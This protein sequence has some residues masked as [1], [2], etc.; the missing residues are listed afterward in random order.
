MNIL[1][2]ECANDDYIIKTAKVNSENELKVEVP[3]CWNCDYVNVVLWED[4][5]C[6]ILEKNGEQ[7]LLVPICGELLLERIQF[8]DEKQYISIPLRYDEQEILIV[9]I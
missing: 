2:I 8:N 7:I 5:I 1:K 6:E 3:V 9:K 4:H